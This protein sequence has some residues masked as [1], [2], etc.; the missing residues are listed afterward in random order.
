MSKYEAYERI[1]KQIAREAKT[2]QK[3]FI[4]PIEIIMKHRLLET[5]CQ[6]GFQASLLKEQ[7]ES[8]Q[9]GMNL[10]MKV[11]VGLVGN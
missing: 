4:N 10:P 3:R 2:T 9:F 1:K 6:T 5:S 11:L 8:F 7:T